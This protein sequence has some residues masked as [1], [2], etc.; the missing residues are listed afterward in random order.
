MKKRCFVAKAVRQVHPKVVESRLFLNETLLSIVITFFV[1]IIT[2]N[3]AYLKNHLFLTTQLV[4]SIPLL[5]TSTLSHI[6]AQKE[7]NMKT[8]VSYGSST[9]ILGYAFLI[10]VIGI[11]ISTE[12]NIYLAVI[13]FIIN[14]LMVVAYSYL[15]YSLKEATL[16][17]RLKKDL[18]FIVLQ[19]FFGLLPAL[20]VY[21]YV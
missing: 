14:W 11:L 21:Y 9:F 13:F 10:N 15:K 8:W 1:L 4:I 5:L 2:L 3:S 18:L 6:T 19:V 7:K 16:K 17:A 20:G 12:I